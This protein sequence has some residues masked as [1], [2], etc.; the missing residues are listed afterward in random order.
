MDAV[1]QHP[2]HPKALRWMTVLH[3]FLRCGRVALTRAADGV[4]P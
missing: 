4:P 1:R 3:R 2:P